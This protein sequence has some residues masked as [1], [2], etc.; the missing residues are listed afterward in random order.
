MISFLPLVKSS[1]D[2]SPALR[3]W[4]KGWASTIEREVEML[5]PSGWFEWG[6]NHNG[7]DINIDGVIY[8][9]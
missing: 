1:L 4:I 8:Q 2:R 3:N 5:E 6:Y 9:G 7:G